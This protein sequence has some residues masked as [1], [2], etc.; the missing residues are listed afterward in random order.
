[1]NLNSKFDL[2]FSVCNCSAFVFDGEIDL[3]REYSLKDHVPEAVL[4][5]IEFGVW[6]DSI[7][8]KE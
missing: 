5:F 1:M 7:S 3:F 8:I 2:N 6:V 4:E